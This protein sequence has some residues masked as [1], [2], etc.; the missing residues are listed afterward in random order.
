MTEQ[1]SSQATNITDLRPK[2]KLNGTVKKVELFGAFVDIGVGRDGLVHI[3][4]LRQGGRVNRVEDIVKEGD[5]VEVFV[6][7]VDPKSG[8]IELT[9]IPPPAIDWGDLAAGQK[10]QGKVK[11]IEKFGAFVDF[12]G[13]REGL[14][15]I[16]AMARERINSPADVV[17]PDQEVTVW[18]TSVDAERQR[19]SLSLVEPPALPWEAIQ[20]GQTYAGKVVRMERF[21]AFVDIGAERPGLLH[22]RE[23]GAGDYVRDASEIVK[24]GDEV[25]V[26]VLE[27]DRRKR[28]IDLTM[29]GVN[30]EEEGPAEQEEIPPTAME[31]A[32]RQ[33]MNSGKKSSRRRDRDREARV[34][35][36]REQEDIMARTLKR[37]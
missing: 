19:I 22:V 18:V 31:L 37:S 33:A 11:T 23:M 17:Q 1:A 20:R 32:M 27:I 3:S 36:R 15:P 16:G 26:K 9:M 13:P 10:Y 25:Q 8:R 30:E 21:G 29:R 2:M 28:Q 6:H 5:T 14:V 7:K 34:Q 12:G 4:R 24:L 35:K